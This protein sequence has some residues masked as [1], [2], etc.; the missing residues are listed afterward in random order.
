MAEKTDKKSS[1]ASQVVVWDGNRLHFE[2]REVRPQDWR[3]AGASEEDVEGVG[4]LEWNH[5]N[6]WRVPRSE[7]PLTD[8]QLG[9]FLERNG[10]RLADA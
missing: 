7:I 3:F 4:I 6:N 2:S 5:A 1:T 8:V 9:A 10:F